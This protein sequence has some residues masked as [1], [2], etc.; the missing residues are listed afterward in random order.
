MLRMETETGWLLITHPDHAHLAA[1]F[2][3]AWGNA[4]FRSPEPRA[5]VLKGISC[6]E[7]G[8]ASRDAHPAITSDGKPSAF[9]E[10][11][12]GK[13]TAFEEIDLDQ[14]LA[15]RQRAV[16]AIA[17]DDPYAALL[18]SMHTLNLLTAHTDRSTIAAKD[19]PFLDRYID[20]Q[21]TE[22]KTFRA[23][24]ASDATLVEEDKSDRAIEENF[25]LMQACAN[26][27][28]LSCVAF[29]KPA[30]LLH[31]LPQRSGGSS[32]VKVNPQGPRRFQLAPWPFYDP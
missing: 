8:W 27:S 2:A 3:A 4:Q 23:A 26:L 7:D 21:K 12:V 17:A 9:S 10:D 15:V 16:Q 28:L 11:L 25:N 32:E 31:P 30:N 18:I 24:I 13:H 19:I 20:H 29:S 6:H 22:Q 1:D 14:Y 5:R